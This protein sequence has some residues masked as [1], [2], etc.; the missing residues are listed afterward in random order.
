MDIKGLI[1]EAEQGAAWVARL[2]ALAKGL[3]G[4]VG[5]GASLVEAAAEGVCAVADEAIII[6]QDH[7]AVAH[8]SSVAALKA[9][10]AKVDAEVEALGA[11]VAAR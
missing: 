7:D 4:G 1:A 3:P 2:A 8:A 10:Q 9:V 6:I 5:A 11:E